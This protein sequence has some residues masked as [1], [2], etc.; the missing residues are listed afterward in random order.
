[1]ATKQTKAHQ[2]IG[3]LFVFQQDSV[4]FHRAHAIVKY[5]SQATFGHLTTP[6]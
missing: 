2:L 5:L 6:I 3:D 4:P 1:M